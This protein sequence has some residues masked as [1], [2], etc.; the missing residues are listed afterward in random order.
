MTCWSQTERQVLVCYCNAFQMT[1]VWSQFE[2]Q[3]PLLRSWDA[4]VDGVCFTVEGEVSP[5][6]WSWVSY[7]FSPLMVKDRIGRGEAGPR[8]VT[9]GNSYPECS[10]QGGSYL[11]DFR[12]FS[13]PF[14]GLLPWKSFFLK[15]VKR[16]FMSL[17]L[18][19][20]YFNYEYNPWSRAS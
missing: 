16:F 4:P 10:L 12:T 20:T 8:S 9:R 2:L 1:S 3:Y 19:K 18:W 13:S 17:A 6:R 5:R 7:A 15:K 14:V 11:T